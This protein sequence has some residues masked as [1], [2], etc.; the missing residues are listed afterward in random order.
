[1]RVDILTLFPEML[2]GPLS[3]SILKRAQ[4][5]GLLEINLVNIRDFSVNKHHTVDDAPYGGGAGMV[6]SPEPLFGAVE[7]VSRELGFMPGVV[8][9]TPQGRP[10]TQA[11]AK[12]LSREKNLIIIC[13]HYEGIDERIRDTLVTDEI[14]IGD[15]VL[16][17]GELPAAVLVDAVA[18]LFQGAGRSRF[19]GGRI[20]HH[21][22]VGVSPLY[23]AQNTVAWRFR[24]YRER[25][26]R[27]SESGGGANPVRTL[28][29][30]PNCS[31]R[32]N[33]RGR[34]KKSWAK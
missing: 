33:Y 4:E 10:F 27:R 24:K 30:R 15:Y 29:R 1:M 34:T 26:P 21:R 7:H 25:P 3:S 20:L 5:R 23:Q 16:T 6:M 31:T 22:F 17:G 13:G 32:L 18:R 14:S 8:L 11:I 28:E 12:N 9:M 19:S 2:S